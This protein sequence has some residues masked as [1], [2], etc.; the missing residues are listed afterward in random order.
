[1]I[2]KERLYLESI[3]QSGSLD[4]KIP[5]N[6]EPTAPAFDP[7]ARSDRQTILQNRKHIY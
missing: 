5:H 2:E 6:F 4:L 1:M 3:K 7:A